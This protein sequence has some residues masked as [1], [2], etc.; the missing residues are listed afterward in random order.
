MMAQLFISEQN[1]LPVK[2]RYKI[3]VVGEFLT[4]NIT[5]VQRIFE[6]NDD[7]HSLCLQDR[8]TLLRSTVKH[9]GCIGGTF[10]L[11]QAH[12]LDDPLFYKSTEL[13]FGSD[14]MSTIIPLTESFDSDATFVK[15]ILTIV[16]F[17]TIRYTNYFDTDSNDLI[18]IKTVIRI[19][20]TYIELAWGY[21]IYKYSYEQ[22]V[23][24]F[25]HLIKNLFKINF[26]VVEADRIQEYKNMIDTVVEQTEQRLKLNN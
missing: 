14:V 13:I 18:D 19:Q 17:S 6:K 2:L 21:M 24:R 4:S 16:A 5:R 25:C 20:D 8:S 7:Y 23:I 3:G 15:L 10:V 1:A 26:T 12:L 22:A 9:T 11:H